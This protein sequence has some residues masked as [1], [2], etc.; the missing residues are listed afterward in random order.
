MSKGTYYTVLHSVIPYT[1]HTLFIKKATAN[2]AKGNYRLVWTIEKITD[3]PPDRRSQIAA[4]V[5]KVYVSL[6]T[7]IGFISD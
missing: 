4:D 7:S 1:T 3:S 6:M 5:E 2:A